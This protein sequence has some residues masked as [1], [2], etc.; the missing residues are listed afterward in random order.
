MARV[1]EALGPLE[2]CGLVIVGL[3][4]VGQSGRAAAAL[5]SLLPYAQLRQKLVWIRAA[6]GKAGAGD[7]LI[8][9]SQQEALDLMRT[10]FGPREVVQW[11]CDD[12]EEASAVLEPPLGHHNDHVDALWLDDVLNCKP[13][14][15]SDTGTAVSSG[16]RF[17]RQLRRDGYCVL[18]LTPSQAKIWQ[19]VE[20]SAAAWFAQDEDTKLDQAGSYGHIDRKFTGYRNGKFREQLEVRATHDALHPVPLAADGSLRFAAALSLLLR[21]LDSI[22]RGLLPHVAAEL[23]VHFDFFEALCDPPPI[24]GYADILR[25]SADHQEPSARLLEASQL[26]AALEAESK[27]IVGHAAASAAYLDGDDFCAP[28]LAH[29]LVRVCRYDA[30]SEGVYGSSVLCEE[31]NDV[32]LL[33]LDVCASV[34]GLQVLR[35]ADRTWVPIEEVA[36]RDD[37]AVPLVCMVGDTLGRLSAGHLSPCKHRVVAPPAGERIGL[38]FLFRGRS[39][40][41]LNTGPALAAARA[42]GWTA[43]LAEM[44]TVTIKEL[45][46]FDSVKSILRNWLRSA[47]EQP[48]AQRAAH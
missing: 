22:A 4:S 39:D 45:P 44:E 14:V 38:P 29:S 26:P 11:G 15:G 18:L 24:S 28:S 9:T 6:A 2:R 10:H 20:S 1:I 5:R 31:H 23:R 19:E 36:P 13:C 30:E 37:G 46:A 7:L 25:T 43:R 27:R 3:R 17:A 34:P 35:H 42:A 32:G 8:S 48:V 40:A 12:P 41:V 21:S 33:T 16:A 47:R